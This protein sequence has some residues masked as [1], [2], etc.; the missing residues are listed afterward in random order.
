MKWE[1]SGTLEIDVSCD[2]I[3]SLQD[4]LTT[5]GSNIKVLK[6]V[7]SCS[8]TYLE[9]LSYLVFVFCPKNRFVENLKGPSFILLGP[10][11]SCSAVSFPSSL[12]T[13]AGSGNPIN[14]FYNY[15]D[16]VCETFWWYHPNTEPAKRPK[17]HSCLWQFEVIS[18]LSQGN[19]IFLDL[20][21]ND[22]PVGQVCIGDSKIARIWSI[23][24]VYAIPDVVYEN[25]INNQKFS[26]ELSISCANTCLLM[27]S[28]IMM[29]AFGKVT[30]LSSKS[31]VEFVSTLIPPFESLPPKS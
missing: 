27:G 2:A 3:S 12:S 14:I 29:T 24:N 10:S 13:F 8:D 21:V 17:F 16:H 31:D 26:F 4:L 22:I 6:L 20:C 19:K 28:S 23:S 15:G 9:K 5:V 18:D 25:L 11:T 1:S 7:G 30:F